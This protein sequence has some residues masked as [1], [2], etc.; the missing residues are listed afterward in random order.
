MLHESLSCEGGHTNFDGRRIEAI[1]FSH[2]CPEKAQEFNAQEL[3][4]KA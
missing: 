3:V 2:K 4:A 1:D